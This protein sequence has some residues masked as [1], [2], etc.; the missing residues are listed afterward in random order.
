M[1][2]KPTKAQEAAASAS[3][4]AQTPAATAIDFD[5]LQKLVTASVDPAG[6]LYTSDAERAPLVTAAYVVVN[7]QMVEAGTN[8]IA[9]RATEAGAAALAAHL[10]ATPAASTPAGF[11]APAAAGAAPAA[12][13]AAAKPAFALVAN[14]PI[15]ERK[16]STIGPRGETY[17][18]GTMEIGQAFF[19]AAT[20]DKPNPERSFASSV[21]SATQRYAVEL[22]GQT[23]ANRKGRVVP[24]TQNTRTFRIARVEDGAPFG[25]PGVAGA[26]VWRTA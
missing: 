5:L 19:I 21:A 17:P 8:K 14:V 26:G 24:A 22:P 15:P 9:T 13:P 7:T 4:Q 20:A 6:F 2:K 23:R 1:A 11:G 10:A 25:Q 12:A 3:A 16:K 18:F